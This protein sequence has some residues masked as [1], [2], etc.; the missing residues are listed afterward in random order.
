[1]AGW[2]RPGDGWRAAL[3]RIPRGYIYMM[4]ALL[5][6]YM[7]ADARGFEYESDDRELTPDLA[8]LIRIGLTVTLTP[9]A[10]ELAYR[11][12]LLLALLRVMPVACAMT[13]CS[14][15]FAAAHL[16]Y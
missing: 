7:A 15:L 12:I 9:F 1:M 10:D 16:G 5:A 14:A 3:L 2:R 11:G 4:G 8:G 6:I 13:L